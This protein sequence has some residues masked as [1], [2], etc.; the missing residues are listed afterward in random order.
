MPR[1]SSFLYHIIFQLLLAQSQISVTHHLSLTVLQSNREIAFD[2][3]DVR[4][5]VGEHAEM[6]QAIKSSVEQVS[7][8]HLSCSGY[9]K[10]ILRHLGVTE[11]YMTCIKSML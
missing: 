7:K 11:Y 9:A 4:N 10:R 2:L 3:R 6:E 8:A 1:S 5:L